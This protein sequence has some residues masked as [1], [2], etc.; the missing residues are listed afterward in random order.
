MNISENEPEEPQVPSI[1]V[2]DDDIDTM[3]LVKFVARSEGLFVSIKKGGLSAL[4]FLHDLN[5]DLDAIIIDLS[6]P[7]MDGIMLTKQI[8]QNENLR[9]KQNPMKVYWFTAWPFNR[10]NPNDPIMVG[11]E[12]NRVEKI[13]SKEDLP[14]MIHAVKEALKDPSAE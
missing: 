12:E 10:N 11:A 9:S 7:D 4:S 2:V 13:F 3:S 6:M 8:R 5:Y 1:M 14:S